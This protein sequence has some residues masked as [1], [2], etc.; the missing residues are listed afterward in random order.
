MSTFLGLYR[1]T[2]EFKLHLLDLEL[3][4]MVLRSL[5]ASEN[6]WRLT[7][8][9]FMYIKQIFFFFLFKLAR[10]NICL[11]ECGFLEGNTDVCHN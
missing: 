3:H 11:V 5:K 6:L 7:L 2:V 10:N 9:S 8:R 4:L 1:Q